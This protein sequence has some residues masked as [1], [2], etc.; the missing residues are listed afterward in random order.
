M[1]LITNHSGLDAAGQRTVDLLYKTRGVKLK[2]IFS[3]EHGFSG[4][5][6]EIVPVSFTR[7]QK[8][9]LR[10]YSLYGKVYRPSDSM[11]KGLDA[12]VFDIQDSGAR[13]Y[14]YITT[15]AYA[16]EAAARKGIAFYVLDRPNPIT[17]SMGPGPCNG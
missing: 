8:T 7:E 3:P 1:G 10:V 2:A 5:A 14:T 17:A 6:D 9:G 16:M 4:T 13:F 12:L 15:L 11:L